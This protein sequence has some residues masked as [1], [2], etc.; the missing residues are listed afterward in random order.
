MKETDKLIKS[1]LTTSN[2][3]NR[4]VAIGQFAT[5]VKKIQGE[6]TEQVES[7]KVKRFI[8]NYSADTDSG[9]AFMDE[10]PYRDFF[11]AMVNQEF[12]YIV[13]NPEDGQNGYY[14][15][16]YIDIQNEETGQGHF[17]VQRAY[18]E[19]LYENG[20]TN[21]YVEGF[22]IVAE[23]F[24]NVKINWNDRY[25][26]SD[27]QYENTRPMTFII[28]SDTWKTTPNI[29]AIIE[30]CAEGR[31]MHGYVQ[32]KDKKKI[33]PLHYLA[34]Q[35]NDK[36]TFYYDEFN[37]NNVQYKR[38]T[39]TFNANGNQLIRDIDSA[40]AL[41]GYIAIGGNPAV[42]KIPRIKEMNSSGN[43][44]LPRS[45]EFVAPSQLENWELINTDTYIWEEEDTGRSIDKDQNKNKFALKKAIFI[46]EYP[47]Y[48]GSSNIPTTPKIIINSDEI[49]PALPTGT[50]GIPSKGTKTIG[51]YEIEVNGAVRIEKG[52]QREVPDDTDIFSKDFCITL[53]NV[54]EYKVLNNQQVSSITL[55]GVVS[56][57]AYA[58]CKYALYG[59]RM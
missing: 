57:L 2:E 54:K 46:Y 18:N 42:G 16:T 34:G 43:T 56:S 31:I 23:D 32:D 44:S 26:L 55:L 47:K 51:Y 35:D 29:S 21:T 38:Y 6:A 14:Y 45:W 36:F 25:V 4:Q 12:C 50:L 48:T 40:Y 19:D 33:H 28:D 1:I 10:T 52:F 5:I 58:G 53:D 9:L 37:N 11:Q 7:N 59:V 15:P 13:N 39:F 3:T 17:V 20:S 41:A 49:T 30:Y 27:S 8:M 24:D 22:D